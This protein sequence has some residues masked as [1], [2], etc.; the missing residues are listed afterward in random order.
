[1]E[2]ARAVRQ[3][4]P[5]LPLRKVATRTADR[6]KCTRNRAAQ[7]HRRTSVACAYSSVC[8]ELHTK[9][10]P[11]RK[12]RGNLRLRQVYGVIGEFGSRTEDASDTSIRLAGSTICP[13]ARHTRARLGVCTGQQT[14]MSKRIKVA[15]V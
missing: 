6:R 15:F 12:S 10:D 4:A 13:I 7:A 1:M 5:D 2:G 14:L 8:R 3:R 11:D 9:C